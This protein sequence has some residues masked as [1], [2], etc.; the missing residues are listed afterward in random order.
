MRTLEV[1]PS[2]LD[3]GRLQR[4]TARTEVRTEVPRPSWTVLI[5]ATAVVAGITW[6][7]A[8]QPR[9][10]IDPRQ[11]IALNL[12]AAKLA[13]EDNRLV[14]PA[15]HSAAYYYR[16]V[17]AIDPANEAARAGVE[18]V[19]ETLLDNAKTAIL[20]G[21]FADAVDAIDHARRIAPNHRRTPYVQT[22]LRKALDAYA[23]SVQMQRTLSQSHEEEDHADSLASSV[24]Q[25]S[26]NSERSEVSEP[27]RGPSRAIVDVPDLV[28]APEV[29]PQYRD[30]EYVAVDTAYRLAR[31]ALEIPAAPAQPEKQLQ[32]ELPPIT[33]SAERGLPKLVSVV[34]PDYPKAAHVRGLEGWVDLT[35]SVSA[36]GRV[37]D[38]RVEDRKGTK[39][40]ER[41]ALSAVRQWRYE[42]TSASASPRDIPARV[43]FRL[44]K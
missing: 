17:L 14:E 34:E 1:A 8:R 42:A 27:A 30:E 5:V 19:A 26:S 44:A 39:S 28:A 20:S 31:S 13:M 12:S 40:F 25:V 11:V 9:D 2:R 38:A 22:E 4:A 29:T 37:L 36:D 33:V 23:A 18:S 41:A 32:Q 10:E 21:R 43:E 7:I 15:E 6:G 3:V 24:P 35:L 16:M